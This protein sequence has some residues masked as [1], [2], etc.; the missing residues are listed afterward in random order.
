MPAVSH[1][2]HQKDLGITAPENSVLVNYFLFYITN[3][4]RFPR[5]RKEILEYFGQ[6]SYSE[7]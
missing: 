1:V 5:K 3:N 6:E 4:Q 2:F 7:E